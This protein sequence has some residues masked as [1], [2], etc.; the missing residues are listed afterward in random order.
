MIKGKLIRLRQFKSEDDCIEYS[1]QYENLEHRSEYD[2]TEIISFTHIMTSFKECGCWNNQSGKLIIEDF[3][4]NL[5]GAVDYTQISEYEIELGYR[6]FLQENRNRGLGTEALKLFIDYLFKAKPIN[7][8]TLKIASDN[9]PSQKLA[10][11]CGFVQ[12]GRLRNAYFFRGDFCDFLIFGLLKNEY[13]RN[14]S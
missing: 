2:H 1:K 14:I 3:D 9:I 11:K 13:N 7:R 4:D 5:L 12:E 10:L 6:I 8:I